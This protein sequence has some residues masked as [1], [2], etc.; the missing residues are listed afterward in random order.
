MELRVNGCSFGNRPGMPLCPKKECLTFVLLGNHP[1][2][3]IRDSRF[4]LA[5]VAQATGRRA[6]RRHGTCKRCW[7]SIA[8]FQHLS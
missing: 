6:S 3:G 7:Y 1:E 4:L 5:C 8:I 2:Q